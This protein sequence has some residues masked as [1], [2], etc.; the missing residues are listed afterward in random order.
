MISSGFYTVY[1]LFRAVAHFRVSFKDQ[2]AGSILI[3]VVGVELYSM[4]FFLMY[5]F[6]VLMPSMLGQNLTDDSN[7][8]N[9]KSP[10]WKWKKD[11][12]LVQ[13]NL[14]TKTS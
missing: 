13:S 3:V 14:Q 4:L 9:V 8:K 6:M 1:F 7:G 2:P 11:F 10:N 12:H 5:D